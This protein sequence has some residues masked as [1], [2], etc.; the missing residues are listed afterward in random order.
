MQRTIKRM[1]WESTIKNGVGKYYKKEWS[2]I[3]DRA[4]MEG[5]ERDGVQRLQ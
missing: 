4:G 2:G 1:E 5:A 3:E